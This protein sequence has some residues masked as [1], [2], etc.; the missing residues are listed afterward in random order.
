MSMKTSSQFDVFFIYHPY[1]LMSVI[2]L[3]VFNRGEYN[4]HA[5]LS[6]HADLLY[7]AEALFCHADLFYHA[8]LF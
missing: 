7:H 3:Y 2:N 4:H 8:G 6:Y 5:A 1:V